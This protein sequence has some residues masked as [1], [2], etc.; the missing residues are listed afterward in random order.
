MKFIPRPNESL[1]K[2]DVP[3]LRHATMR[4][5]SGRRCACGNA[6]KC[7][8]RREAGVADFNSGGNHRKRGRM[9][10][11]RRPV[12]G[13]V[14]QMADRAASFGCAVV[15]M[16]DDACKR[17]ADQQQRK[18]RHRNQ[19]KSRFSSPE[20]DQEAPLEALPSY[21]R[22]RHHPTGCAGCF[23]LRALRAGFR[24]VGAQTRVR[25]ACDPL[26]SGRF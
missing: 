16:P 21:R 23:R 9:I 11:C 18:Q 4:G 19:P 1:R 20:Y 24:E 15:M 6:T 2:S 10:L 3:P 13:L 14:T 17:H 7:G 8:T 12:N 22:C 26:K 25:T 5:L